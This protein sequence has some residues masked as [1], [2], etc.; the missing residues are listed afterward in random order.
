MQK[1]NPE[2]VR[3]ARFGME[4]NKRDVG[5][6]Q[7]SRRGEMCLIFELLEVH[8]NKV[9]YLN[10]GKVVRRTEGTRWARWMELRR[11]LPV[12]DFETTKTIRDNKK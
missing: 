3:S 10:F 4:V 6:M 9:R 11:L 7:S 12:H 1:Q 5:I 2:G 8:G